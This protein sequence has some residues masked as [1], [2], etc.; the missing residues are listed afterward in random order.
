MDNPMMDNELGSQSLTI[1]RLV[2]ISIFGIFLIYLVYN[3]L[4]SHLSVQNKNSSMVTFISFCMSSICLGIFQSVTIMH[5]LGPFIKYPQALCIILIYT[6]CSILTIIISRFA[7]LLKDI[8]LNLINDLS[9]ESKKSDLSRTRVFL[10]VYVCIDFLSRLVISCLGD[11]HWMFENS[12]LQ[13]VLIL[14]IIFSLLSLFIIILL[15]AIV[16]QKVE[17]QLSLPLSQEINSNLR[18]Y[19]YTFVYIITCF[20]I[21]VALGSTLF[22]INDAIR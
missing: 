15:L 8:H 6:P 18:Y 12:A 5:L 17:Q 4:K 21:S 1:C 3:G 14:T 2:L 10:L 9:N 7:Y 11:Q 20:W 13:T 19:G 16:H 22:G